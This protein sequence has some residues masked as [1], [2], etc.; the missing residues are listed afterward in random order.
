MNDV[1]KGAAISTE[2]QA[3]SN[4]AACSFVIKLFLIVA[5]ILVLRL[6]WP[7]MT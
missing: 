4:I 7:K 6:V 1:A 2:Q 5:A 3:S